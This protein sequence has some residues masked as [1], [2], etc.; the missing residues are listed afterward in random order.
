M[1]NYINNLNNIPY[2][3]LTKNFIFIALLHIFRL[4]NETL[5]QVAKKHGEKVMKTKNPIS[6]GIF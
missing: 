1:W 6:L 5:E 3:K 4:L 2:I